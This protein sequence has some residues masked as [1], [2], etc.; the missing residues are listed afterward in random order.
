MN[1]VLLSGGSGKRLWPLSNDVRSKQ[2]IKFFDDG[3]GNRESM[4]QRMY[5]MIRK[6]D[7]DAKV[8]IA[9]SKSQISEL[10]NQL[11]GD[12]NISLEPCRRDTFPA[13]VLAVSYLHDVQH[14]SEEE[15]VVICPVDP[16]VE[17]DYFQALKRL[18]ELAQ[19]GDS[20]LTLM[21]IKPTYPS[22]KYGY[23]IPESK[24][25]VA[26]VSL[27]KEKPTCEVAKSYLE[28]GALWNGGIFA[29]KIGYLLNKAKEI[30]GHG[31]YSWLFDNYASLPKISFD[32]AV[33]EKE[34]SIDVMRFAGKWVDLGSWNTLTDTLGENGN[35]GKALLSED[36][37][38]DHVVNELD[39]PVLCVGVSNLIVA[40][41]PEGVLVTNKDGSARIKPYVDK[42][43]TP[44]MFAEKSWGEYKVID[45]SEKSVTRKITLEEGHQMSYH[46][47]ERRD[48]VWTIISGNGTT[49][50]DGV[51][52]HVKPGDVISI[53]TGVK[54]TIKANS[55]VLEIIE[56]QIG[57]D[58]SVSD[59]KKW[60]L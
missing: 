30:L 34:P 54:H 18:S 5:H 41:S 21:G 1:I 16:Y 27:F 42:L 51:V 14:V 57:K 23:I 52:K 44:V 9:T 59:K 6:V 33:V 53:K 19:K 22:E 40:A 45:V 50:L 55:D 48:E 25:S 56:V 32:Y 39:I 17:E 31:E 7:S 46:S 43:D 38:N 49:I 10:K 11:G 8:T 29:F 37:K 12:I 36:C 20:N 4:V 47:H 15:S 26:K 58:I 2:F 60:K 3:K 13:I 35:V 28:Q 24:D